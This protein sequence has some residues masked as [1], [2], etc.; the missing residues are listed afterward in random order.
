MAGSRPGCV[1]VG[2]WAS[3]LKHGT[4]GLKE[5]AKKILYAQQQ[6]KLAFDGDKDIQII[7]KTP[8][9]IISFTSSSVNCIAMSELLIKNHHWGV[10]KLQ[11]PHGAH[12]AFTDASSEHWKGLVSAIKQSTELMKKDE[13]L[14]TN[15]DTA[16]YGMTSAIPDRSTLR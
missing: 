16:V 6:V 12:F 14:N 4:N 10:A 11:R 2:T 1:I 13:S 5:K 3:F 7:S 8:S 9:P 15:Q